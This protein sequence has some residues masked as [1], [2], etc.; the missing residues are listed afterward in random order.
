MHR[1]I[2][3]QLSSPKQL[4]GV[5][6]L[7]SVDTPFVEAVSFIASWYLVVGNEDRFQCTQECF[8]FGV[9]CQVST[10]WDLEEPSG[11]LCPAS[12]T[13][14]FDGKHAVLGGTRLRIRIGINRVAMGT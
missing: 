4:P 7:G 2:A 14:I 12:F 3:R 5:K 1:A 13:V 8:G 6:H 9:P 11:M 10:I